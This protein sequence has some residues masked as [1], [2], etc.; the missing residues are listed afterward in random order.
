[1]SE[2]SALTNYYAATAALAQRLTRAVMVLKKVY[3]RLAGADALS[4]SQTQE[5]RTQVQEFIEGLLRGL[6][7]GE[8]VREGDRPPAVPGP[9]LERLRE[10]KRGEWTYFL[11]DLRTARD[12]LAIGIKALT[13]ADLR[14][15]DELCAVMDAEASSTFRMLQRK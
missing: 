14:L 11:Q 7:P 15:I 12:H 5:S 10:W 2:L 9:V 6:S 4:E 3:Y 8:K 1:M 13:D